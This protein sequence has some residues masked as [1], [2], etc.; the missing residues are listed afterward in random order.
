M[1]SPAKSSSEWKP[2]LG[3]GR[4]C[5]LQILCDQLEHTQANL[6]RLEAE[7]EQLLTSDP[8]VKGVQQIPEFGSKT[9]AVLR[10]ELGNMQRFTRIDEIIA[11]GRMDI[12]IKESGKWI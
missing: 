8:G 2:H 10:A 5:I 1:R 11:Y 12:E 6:A 3:M 7:I 9:V 4:I